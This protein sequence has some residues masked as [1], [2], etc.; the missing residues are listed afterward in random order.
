[1]PGGRNLRESVRRGRCTAGL[2]VAIGGFAAALGAASGAVALAAHSSVPARS[3]SPTALDALPFPGTPDAAP[4]TNIDLPAASPAQ[5]ASVTAVGSRSGLHAG[6]LSAQPAG[7]GTA[8]TPDRPFSPG[9]RVTV[10][11]TFRSATAGTASGAPG[12]KQI[13]YSFSIA[14]PVSDMS[15]RDPRCQHRSRSADWHRD[16]EQ[17]T[18]RGLTPS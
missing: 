18:A 4:G 16:G 14:R 11:A 7:H 9:E 6:H 1:M 2:T 15:R 3:A 5:V 17:F 12:A 8:F 13:S 10:T